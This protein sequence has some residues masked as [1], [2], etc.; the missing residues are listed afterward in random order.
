MRCTNRGR[1]CSCIREDCSPGPGGQACTCQD[2]RL[3]RAESC[4]CCPGRKSL[5]FLRLI[6]TIGVILL[7]MGL[8]YLSINTNAVLR[9][10]QDQDVQK[11]SWIPIVCGIL[12]IIFTFVLPFTGVILRELNVIERQSLA[13]RLGIIL[14]LIAF[15]MVWIYYDN[16][17]VHRRT[18][19]K[20]EVDVTHP[21][22]LPAPAFVVAIGY[23][24]AAFAQFRRT[25]HSGVLTKCFWP[26]YDKSCPTNFSDAIKSFNSST[27]G[28]LWYLLY[29]PNSTGEEYSNLSQKHI[30]QIFTSWDSAS[31]KYHYNT[32]APQLPYYYYSIF[33]S[34]LNFEKGLECGLI[35]LREMPAIGSNSFAIT[36]SFYDDALNVLH[37]NS[38]NSDCAELGRQVYQF[39]TLLSSTGGYNYT[40]CDANEKE[41]CISQTLI[42]YATPYVQ[43]FKTVQGK[44]AT[45]ILTDEGGIVGGVAYLSW[46]FT[47]IDQLW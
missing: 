25:P 38:S 28:Q 11:N 5:I 35:T 13:P 15:A 27:Y 12:L 41:A 18:A 14:G 36:A 43:S 17:A 40:A 22:T 46:L 6:T 24:D 29:Q 3:N 30:F 1:I 47:V 32:I 37:V 4:K 44:S 9:N 19:W 34:N 21:D 31:I 2:P 33:D 7:L 8:I 26:E 39:E 20:F 23:G 42:R 45:D 16:V 10:D